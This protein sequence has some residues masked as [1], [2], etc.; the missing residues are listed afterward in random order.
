MLSFP[1]AIKME[2]GAALSGSL[3]CK[4]VG[5]GTP[6]RMLDV[7]VEIAYQGMAARVGYQLRRQPC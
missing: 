1:R 4:P 2:Q 6:G 3:S 5:T 7:D